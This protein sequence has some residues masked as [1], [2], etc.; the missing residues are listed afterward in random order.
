MKFRQECRFFATGRSETGISMKRLIDNDIDMIDLDAEASREADSGADGT[1]GAETDG[2]SGAAADGT[3]GAA[4]EG[5]SRATADKASGTAARARSRKRF[6]INIHL[7]LLLVV[8]LFISLVC[9]RFFN[10]GERIDL[11]EIFK[12]GPGTYEDT[13][14]LFL[15]LLDEDWN[16][17]PTDYSDGLTIVA[18]GNYPF[19]DDRDSKDGLLNM[20]AQ[21]TDA[22]VYNCSVSGSYLATH[23][24]YLNTDD[25]PMDVY[26]LYWLSAVAAGV[27]MEGHYRDAAMQLGDSLPPDA[28]EAYDTLVSIDFDTVDVITIMYDATDYLM[29]NGIYSFDNPTDITQTAG[30][31]EAA[32]EYFQM[33]YP[34]IRI[35]VMS[36]TY[37]YAVDENGDYVSSSLVSYN[38]ENSDYVLSLYSK[39]EWNTCSMRSVSYVDHLRGTF[40]EEGA[41]RYLEDNLHLNK[42]GRELVADRFLEALYSFGQEADAE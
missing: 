37:A 19:S 21:K 5:I 8:I 32:I 31:L 15:P 40:N 1:S 14:D 9:Y 42:K 30:N 28:Q 25:S 34:H 36:P 35:I 17:I 13:D 33:T 4:A 23:W 7:V 22:T 3:F 38:V 26:S 18:F 12:D 16:K 39:M 6:R 10:W 27:D 20:I 41:E 29:G 24:D 2:T 11:E